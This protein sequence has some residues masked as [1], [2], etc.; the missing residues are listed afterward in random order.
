MPRRG[1]RRKDERGRYKGKNTMYQRKYYR[2]AIR[3]YPFAASVLAWNPGYTLGV[4]AYLACAD[5][6]ECD[7]GKGLCK[8]R[9]RQV[10]LSH[11][12]RDE[13]AGKQELRKE[14]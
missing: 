10:L 6:V 13:G 8:H 9:G 12:K 2:A 3:Q 4:L 1:R 14:G 11:G 5:L 7:K